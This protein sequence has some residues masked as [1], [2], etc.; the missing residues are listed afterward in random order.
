MTGSHD[1]IEH[2][3]IFQKSLSELDNMLFWISQ[4]ALQNGLS[5]KK[6]KDLEIASEEAITNIVRHA[7][8][9]EVLEVI[10]LISPTQMQVSFVDQGEAFN[11][12]QQEPPQQDLS[13]E[14]RA[15]GGLG[16]LLM[17]K[18]VDH[19]HYERRGSSNVL[20]LIKKKPLQS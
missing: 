4:Y 9:D 3:K 1:E 5:P 7:R 18:L 6:A 16:I 20:S 10:V 17:K 11:P 13:L 2:R 15:I 8:T 19:I 14:E 12:L